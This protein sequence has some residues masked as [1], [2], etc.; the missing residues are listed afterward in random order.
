C[1]P[2]GLRHASSCPLHNSK[3]LYV[4][5]PNQPF[6]HTYRHGCIAGYYYPMP[7]AFLLSQIDSQFNDMKLRQK[8][9]DS[10]LIPLR[11]ID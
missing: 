3:E 6:R 1:K 10:I 4:C 8:N 9:K 2:L 7:T 11:K 5:L